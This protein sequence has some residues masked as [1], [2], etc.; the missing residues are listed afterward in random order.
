MCKAGFDVNAIV[1]PR[2]LVLPPPYTAHWLPDGSAF[3]D[4]QARA[5]QE[6]AGTLVWHAAAGVDG[7]GRFD[8]AVV[9]EPDMPL[10]EARKAVLVG[11]VALGDA[12]ATHAPPER[13]I[14]F[15]WVTGVVFDGSR[16]GGMR[17]AAAP[18]TSEDATPDWMVLGVELIGDRDYLGDR[19][20]LVPDSISLKE[21][22]FEDPPAILE[23]FAAHLMLNFDR[24]NHNGFSTIAQAYAKRLLD[25]AA[26]GEAGER[27]ANGA[28]ESLKTGLETM[29]WRDAQGPR[30]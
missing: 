30:L 11:M 27:V 7:P 3:D 15:D 17:F 22:A 20:G 25:E 24:W 8:F 9:L 2:P 13:D 16:L 1:Q 14:R 26:I 6:G 23:S 29:A 18:G 21:E 19:T 5:P 10:S 28:V 12:L 4:A